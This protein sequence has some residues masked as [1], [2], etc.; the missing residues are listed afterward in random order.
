MPHKYINMFKH[1]VPVKN[2]SQLFQ[3][4]L[5]CFC[6][7]AA[8]VAWRQAQAFPALLPGFSPAASNPWT[9][10]PVPGAS[11]LSPGPHPLP[12][13]PDAGF[14]YWVITHVPAFV[15]G[16]VPHPVAWI[17]NS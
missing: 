4:L 13:P 9:D 10:A 16:S 5:H 12:P 1:Y 15:G 11:A 14:R 17:L 6:L 2:K 8:E 3:F 7:V